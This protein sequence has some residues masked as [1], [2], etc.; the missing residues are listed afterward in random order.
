MYCI[1]EMTVPAAVATVNPGVSHD[2]GYRD[3][4]NKGAAIVAICKQVVALLVREG[5][6]ST[7]RERRR[8]K[9][10][11]RTMTPSRPMTRRVNH[12]GSRPKLDRAM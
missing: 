9:R 10:T 7:G 1:P 4:E 3:R 12:Q 8:R 6:A 11:P 5:R 2:D